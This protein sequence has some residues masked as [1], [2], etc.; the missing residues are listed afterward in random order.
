MITV[1]RAE[2]A[3][4]PPVPA[5]ARV[6]SSDRP[7]TEHELRDWVLAGLREITL[8]GSVVLDRAE[9]D[10]YLRVLRLLRDCAAWRVVVRWHGAIAGDLHVAPLRHLSPPLD[11]GGRPMWA[12]VP[13]GLDLRHGP[14]FALVHDAR[15][16]PARNHRIT[17]L[18][19][20]AALRLARE[21][22]P[23]AELRALGDHVLPI[24]DHLSLLATAGDLALSL[25]ARRATSR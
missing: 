14:D 18:P 1:A 12:W 24:L 6:C 11:A 2:P 7:P 25:P 20:L 15:A 22:A 19:L 4:P 10:G 21:P 8:T 3:D 13:E 23:I 5:S 16:A 9:P 17:D